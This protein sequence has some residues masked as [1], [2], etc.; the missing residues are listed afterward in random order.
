MAEGDMA[1]GDMA[2]GEREKRMR[3]V[4]SLSLAFAGVAL[5]LAS[6]P[7]ASQDPPKQ[8]STQG[9]LPYVPIHDPEFISAAEATFMHA[10]DRVIGVV[11]GKVAKAYPAGIMVQHGLVEDKS[12]DGPIAI[13][14]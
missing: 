12:P 5:L 13:T 10:D 9:Y 8:P 11:S 7:L 2:E 14:W 6:V 3:S 4:L 1:E